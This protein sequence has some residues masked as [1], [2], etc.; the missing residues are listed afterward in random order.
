[1][2]GS[3]APTEM[4]ARIGALPATPQQPAVQ[5]MP[6]GTRVEYD[7]DGNP[8]RQWNPDGSV[9]TY[10]P[11]GTSTEQLPD[12][13]SLYLDQSGKPVREV[14]PDGTTYTSFDGQGRPT[15]GVTPAGAGFTLSYDAQG[16]VFE[17]L[18]DGT[19][20]ETDPGGKPIREVTPDG[21]TYTSFDDRGRPTGGVSANG[22]Q[23]T[24]SYDAQGD[25]FETFD[26]GTVLE[27]DPGG[28][29]I[30]E[31]APDGTTY[32]SFDGGGRPTSG[33]TASGIGFT[34]TYDA[35]GDA[36]EK[37]DD[38][39]VLETDPGGKPIREVAPDGTTYT[40]FDGGGRPT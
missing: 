25:V 14:A 29:P 12:G 4:T 20:L 28:K 10:Q 16:D 22:S 34:I 36:F 40:S 18:D 15:S 7:A 17:K 9:R 3:D 2:T 26:N 19:V 23:F 30:R 21:T 24:L 8:T 39:T 31:V 27:T 33:V 13:T 35:Q 11:D 38:G 6:D 32:T 5:T 1:M 37:F